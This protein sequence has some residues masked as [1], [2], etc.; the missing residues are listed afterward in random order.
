MRERHDSM[1]EGR[2]RGAWLGDTGGAEAPERDG[3][4]QRQNEISRAERA[5]RP[6]KQGAVKKQGKL[7]AP[8]VGSEGRWNK[9]RYVVVWECYM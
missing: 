7:V 8:G 5:G 1:R 6:T 9:G 2:R 3:R 4:A